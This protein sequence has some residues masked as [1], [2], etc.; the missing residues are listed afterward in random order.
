MIERG[1]SLSLISVVPYLTTLYLKIEINGKNS[2]AL[3]AY[4]MHIK[5]LH[6]MQFLDKKK[7]INLKE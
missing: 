4:A 7:N 6:T 2:E 3:I 5:E 1:W